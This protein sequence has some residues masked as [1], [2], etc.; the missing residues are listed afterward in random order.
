[1]GSSTHLD[2][3]RRGPAGWLRGVEVGLYAR[4]FAVNALILALAVSVLAFTP[5]SVNSETTSTQFAVLGAGL[6]VMLAANALLLRLSLAPLRRLTELMKS[7]DLLRPGARLRASGSTEVSAVIAAFN[8]TLGRLES[9]R[10]SSTRRIVG[11][12]E[13]ERRRI[14]QELHDEIGQNLTAVMLELKRARPQVSPAV[15]EALADV[16]ELARESLDEL[17]R[18]SYQLRPAALDDLGLGSALTILCSGLSARTGI[19]IACDVPGAR[20]SGLTPDEELALYRIAQEALTNALRHSGCSAINVE[21]HEDGSGGVTLRVS[22]DGAGMRSGA[23][24]SGGIRGMRERALMID[25]QLALRNAPQ[26]GLQV[27]A[28]LTADRGG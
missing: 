11:T 22:D 28:V 17:R 3:R 21:L 4:V 23:P 24:P 16:Q 15:A 25:S 19:P 6:C 26:G 27:E 5:A 20:L 12:Q 9:E 10:R 13:A 1:M 7:A 8:A 2:N 18:I 14:A